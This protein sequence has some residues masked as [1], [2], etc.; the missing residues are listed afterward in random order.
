MD[1][2]GLGYVGDWLDDPDED[3]HEVAVPE[4]TLAELEGFSIFELEGEDEEDDWFGEQD[5][6]FE[7]EEGPESVAEVEGY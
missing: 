2:F 5:W 3:D 7:D 4:G 1:D 6:A